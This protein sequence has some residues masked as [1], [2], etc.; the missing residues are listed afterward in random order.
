MRDI[1]E[2]WKLY[3][4]EIE[5]LQELENIF[6]EYD[7]K[8][9]NE[10]IMDK[11]NDYMLKLSMKVVDIAKSSGKKALSLLSG[12]AGIVSRFKDK[13]PTLANILGTI[14]IAGGVYAI[15]AGIDPSVAQ[16][17]VVFDGKLLSQ[18]ELDAF[19]GI[20]KRVDLSGSG[21]SKEKGFKIA[22][23]LRDLHNAENVVEFKKSMDGINGQVSA[24][25]DRL[26]DYKTEKPELYSDLVKAG[27][28]F[29]FRGLTTGTPGTSP[30]D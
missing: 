10:G 25:I 6:L 8:V 26:R 24:L 11:I 17:D 21:I 3:K 1:Y 22:A 19:E 23:N 4:E 13:Y 5:L 15:M 28:N 14:I 29:S 18:E 2:N 9:L 12:A 7:N 16:A 27:E 30:I 20:V